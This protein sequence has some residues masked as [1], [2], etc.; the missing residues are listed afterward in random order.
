MKYSPDIHHR[1]SIRLKGYDYSQAG[2]YFV[3][4]CT[5]NRECLFGEITNGDVR[6][7][8]AGR[9]VERWWLELS[10]KFPTIEIGRYIIMPNHLHGILVFQYHKVVGADLRVCPNS[11]QGAHIGAPLP[12]IVQW[13]KTMTSNEY[14][15]GAQKHTWPPLQGKLWQRNYFE[16]IIRNEDELI[17]TSEYILNN[18]AIWAEDENN[19][20]VMDKANGQNES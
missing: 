8:D 18:P 15:R 10:K 7:N 16:R 2:V 5:Q 12:T 9:M 20:M 14:I 6:L 19:P 4:I 3:T 13:F 1:R 11:K 17:R